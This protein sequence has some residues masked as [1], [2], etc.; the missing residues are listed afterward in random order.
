MRKK[1]NLAVKV[2]GLIGAVVLVEQSFHK[3]KHSLK[4][5]F[6]L[7]EPDTTNIIDTTL[8]KV[9]EFA[10]AISE[11][12]SSDQPYIIG[13]SSN[14]YLGKYQFG[15]LAMQDIYGKEKGL[16]LYKKY[17]K[18]ITLFT[19]KEQDKAFKKWVKINQRYLKKEIKKYKNKIVHGILITESGLI[20]AAHNQ[21]WGSVRRWL[22][23]GENTTDAFGTEIEVYLKDFKNCKL[24]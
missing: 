21:G 23:S 12:E 3:K 10:Q 9:T 22:A 19:E 8:V 11:A 14:H 1:F 5:E 4:C 15:L 2:I 16:K 6:V 24:V 17:H 20:A 7:T 18:D 13:G